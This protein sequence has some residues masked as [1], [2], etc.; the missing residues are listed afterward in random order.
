MAPPTQTPDRL[1]SV[2]HAARYFS[3]NSHLFS[4]II[5]ASGVRAELHQV[6]RASVRAEEGGGGSQEG[7]GAA[8]GR[9][10]E[11]GLLHRPHR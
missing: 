10:G 8:G 1:S 2:K 4:L 9:R 5:F 7:E 3:I 6:P 11:Q